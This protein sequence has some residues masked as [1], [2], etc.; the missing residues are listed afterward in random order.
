METTIIAG[1]I[2]VLG[3]SFIVVLISYIIDS[4]DFF[5]RLLK[6]FLIMFVMFFLLL[7]PKLILDSTSVC[8]LMLNK[9]VSNNLKIYGDNFTVSG[10]HWDTSDG[11]V[12]RDSNQPLLFHELDNT[13]YIYSQY[14]YNTTTTQTQSTIYGSY[15]WFIRI[16]AIMLFVYV[17]YMIFTWFKVEK[18][19]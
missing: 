9:T 11:S 19:G 10:I 4:S 6:L 14:C 15:L 12:P 3:V 1:L 2:G 17:S 16:C 5:L 18:N 13:T 7:A 8:D